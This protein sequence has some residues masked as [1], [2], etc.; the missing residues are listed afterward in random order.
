MKKSIITLSLMLF[1]LMASAQYTIS[2][3]VL[4]KGDDS[5]LQGASVM[6]KAGNTGVTAGENGQFNLKASGRITLLVTYTGYQPYEMVIN[7]APDHELLI[8]LEQIANELKEVIVSTGYQELPKERATGSFVQVDRQLLNRSVSTDI[9]SRLAD[10]VPG[11]T[12]NRIGNKANEQTSISIRGQ[13]TLF[14]KTSPLIVVD[15]YPYEG[16]VSNINPNDVESVTVLKDAAAASIWG[17]RAGNGVIVITT[18]KGRFDEPVKVSFN[19]NLSLSAKPDLFYTPV[20][21]TSDFIATERTLFANGYYKNQENSFNKVALTPVVELLIAQRDGKMTSAQADAAIS[22]LEANDVRK[23]ISKYLY[24]TGTS[25]QY[26]LSLSGGSNIQRFY[27]SGGYDDNRSTSNGNGYRRYT[28]D[29]NNTY[30]LLNR[31]LT[32]GTGIFATLSTTL[33]NA[34]PASALNYA[35]GKSIYPYAQLADANGTALALPHT[36][37]SALIQTAASQGL[38]DWN[39]TPLD[40]LHAMDQRT[41]AADYRFNFDSRY[42]IMPGLNA[43][44]LYQYNRVTTDYRNN[45]GLASWYTRDQINRLTTVN[46][47]GSLNRPIPEGGILDERSSLS[48]SH[49]VRGQLSFER[50]FPIDHQLNMIAGAELRDIHSTG[51]TT[52]FYGYDPEHAASQPV[53]YISAFG[54]YINPASKST[55]IQNFDGHTDLTD[56]FISYYTNAGYTLHKRYLLSG[57]ARLDQSNLFGV[58]TNQ[59]G[60]PLYSAGF[61]WKLSEEPFYKVTWL[62]NLTMRITHGTSGNIDKT[63]SAYTTAIYFSAANNFLGVPYARIQNPPNPQ[64]RWE[65]VRT[66]DLGLDFSSPDERLSGSVDL[67]IKKGSDLIGDAPLAPQTGLVQFRGNT[68][69]TQTKGVDI[70]LTSRNLTGPFQWS[71][72]FLFTKL[73]EKVTGYALSSTAIARDYLSAAY[74]ASPATG[75]PLY[76]IYSYEWAGLD[77]KTGDPQ[78]YLNGQV[79]KDYAAIINSATLQT[80]KYNGPARPTTYGALRNTFGYKQFSLSANIT[81]RFGYYTRRSSVQYNTVLSGLGGH[82]DYALRWQAPGDEAHTSIPSQPATINGNRDNFYTY[83]SV[84][85]QKGDNIRLQDVNLG[86]DLRGASLKRLPFKGLHFY[87]YA[88]NLGLLWKAAKNDLDPDAVNG[89]ILPL[90]RTIA[91]GIK[92]DL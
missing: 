81:Y 88:N 64:L 86:Y 36:Y 5:P 48:N 92:A 19:S 39:Y 10:V 61:S 89:D 62:P 84:L 9:I 35:P 34:L 8:R 46:T 41:G 74:S 13:S 53:D 60:V 42:Q 18:K 30:S 17:T 44:I 67:Y 14:A 47:D 20:M 87:I 37:R 11:L 55:R 58:S 90:P 79:S 28:L 56:R 82:G 50:N 1:S 59:K 70:S 65:R 22:R 26:S 3:R 66:T 24:R 23:D 16:D 91:F 72:T 83:S 33:Q 27:V 76:A 75:R 40:E 80:I 52:R 69:S 38:L 6:I 51:S 21:S 4:S 43:S 15:N 63:L 32:I 25:Q 7:S 12:F 54:T 31:K 73:N 85:V 78:G 57:S 45:Q 71:T 49:T 68:A 29:A 77:P 2:G